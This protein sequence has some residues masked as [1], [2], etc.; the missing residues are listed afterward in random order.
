M[1]GQ[2]GRPAGSM[3]A[4]AA[5]REAE[6]QAETSVSSTSTLVPTGVLEPAAAFA[7]LRLVRCMSTGSLLAGTGFVVAIVEVQRMPAE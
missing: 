1:L 6:A 3:R 7:V 2:V 4:G 5:C